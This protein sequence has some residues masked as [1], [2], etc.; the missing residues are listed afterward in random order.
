MCF[1]SI[2]SCQEHLSLEMMPYYWFSTSNHNLKWSGQIFIK[3]WQSILRLRPFAQLPTW[4]R[5]RAGNEQ[6]SCRVRKAPP[7][8]C[9][10]TFTHISTH[11]YTHAFTHTPTHT[12]HSTLKPNNRRG[13]DPLEIE[14]ETTFV[15]YLLY[16]TTTLRST[17]HYF[18][19]TSQL[20]NEGIT[21]QRQ[22]TL[23]LRVVNDL[24][25]VTQLVSGRAYI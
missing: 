20:C 23:G 11:T 22:R 5:S 15:G 2:L 17:L 7:Q 21:F 12:Y 3:N 10:H 19:L 6:K 4:A 25:K 18:S 9:T 16:N 24:S 13:E 8:T 1:S 14:R